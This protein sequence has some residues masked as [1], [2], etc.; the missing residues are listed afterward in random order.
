MTR[1]TDDLDKWVAILSKLAQSKKG[2]S[3]N[4]QLGMS[5][6]AIRSSTV[7]DYHKL[8]E[9]L[10]KM[11]EKG[12]I[13]VNEEIQEHPDGSEKVIHRYKI[14]MKGLKFLYEVLIPARRALRGLEE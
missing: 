1:R 10:E 11:E 2:Y 6:Y 7:G 8:S 3:N 5:F 13:S 9:I 12:V 14:T 4:E